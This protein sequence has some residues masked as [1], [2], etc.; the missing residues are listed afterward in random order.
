MGCTD[1]AKIMLWLF[2]G[3]KKSVKVKIKIQRCLCNAGGAGFLFKQF[4]FVFRPAG[5]EPFKFV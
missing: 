4:Q 1:S 2:T 5:I 3:A